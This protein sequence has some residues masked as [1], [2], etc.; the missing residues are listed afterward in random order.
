MKRWEV[1][2]VNFLKRFHKSDQMHESIEIK[3]LIRNSDQSKTEASAPKLITWNF[4]TSIKFKWVLRFVEGMEYDRLQYSS[5]LNMVG[6]SL[7][8]VFYVVH[9]CERVQLK[10]RQHQDVIQYRPIDST[11]FRCLGNNYKKLVVMCPIS[12]KERTNPAKLVHHHQKK[13][14][15][16]HS[17][18]LKREIQ[19]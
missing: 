12:P 16:N 1:N 7:G 5:E 18:E 2:Q 10:I 9:H 19:I 11:N 3:R 4:K 8:Y 17:S 6:K 14:K 13:I 15:F